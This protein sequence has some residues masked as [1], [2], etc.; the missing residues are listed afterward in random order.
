MTFLYQ[1]E[2]LVDAC[3][4]IVPRQRPHPL[5]A[6][7]ARLIAH[8]GAHDEKLNVLENTDAAFKRALDLNCWGIEFDIHA[9][10]DEIL[11]VHHD[12]HLNRLWGHNRHIRDL[13]FPQLRTTVPLIPSLQE[14][15]E[16]YG[17]KMH[18]FIEIK[19][20]FYL[21]EILAITLKLLTPCVDYHLLC[22][23][24]ELFPRLTAYFP[25]ECLLLVPMHNNVNQFYTTSLQQQYGGI[26]GHY[27]L[28]GNKQIQGLNAAKQIV[29][30][31]FVDSKYSLY[32]ELNRGLR[33]LF[34]NH[35]KEVNE[36]LKELRDT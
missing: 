14:V 16:N 32:R 12:P 7:E 31:G 22:L 21:P 30:V 19:M 13:N 23:D 8:R 33:F 6:N 24:D 20:P 15:V 11:V 27:L 3:F 28:L 5:H 25:K 1:I 10:A 17:K 35:V 29:G 34:S 18:L 2:K 36:Y 9:C 4:A 26:L